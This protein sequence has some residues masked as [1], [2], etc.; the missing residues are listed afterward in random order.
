MD[1]TKVR[2]ANIVFIGLLLLTI[3]IRSNSIERILKLEN[4][5]MKRYFV[6]ADYDTLRVLND[7]LRMQLLGMLIAQEATGKQLVDLLQLSPS[8]VHYYL[9]ELLQRNVVEI[10][11]TQKKTAL[12]KNFSA[13]SRLIIWLTRHCCQ[14]CKRN[15]DWPKTS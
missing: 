8:R 6:I 3:P 4:G 7:P 10:V 9:K 1:S 14:P 11:R 2:E 12:C 15:R 5:L 13:R